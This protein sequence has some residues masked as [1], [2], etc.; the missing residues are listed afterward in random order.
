MFFGKAAAAGAGVVPSGGVKGVAGL[1]VGGEGLPQHQGIR[2]G[3]LMV[4]LGGGFGF[5][6]RGRKAVV[7]HAARAQNLIDGRYRLRA[8]EG[9]F[10]R[11]VMLLLEGRVVESA[12][13]DERAALRTAGPVFAETGGG[14]LRFG[15]GASIQRTVVHG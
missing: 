4:E 14:G 6:A 11:A 9:V 8:E 12:I 3:Q 1:A 13:A 7:T 2:R 10:Q 15:G 5:G